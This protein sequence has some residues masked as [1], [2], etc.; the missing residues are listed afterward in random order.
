MLPEG[1]SE[2]ECEE[3]AVRQVP[4]ERLA[5]CAD[6]VDENRC[7]NLTEACRNLCEPGD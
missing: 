7:G 4:E 2:S 6:C 5:D 3:Q 1:L